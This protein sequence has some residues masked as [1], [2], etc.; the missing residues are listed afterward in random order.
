MIRG[1]GNLRGDWLEETGE[2]R[3]MTVFSK[4]A[5]VT[6]AATMVA[7]L[8]VL[9][10][11]SLM[12]VDGSP[13][14][15]PAYTA[16]VGPATVSVGFV[17][18]EGHQAEDAINC[19]AY[20]GITLG[21]SPGRFSPDLPITRWQ[22]ALFLTRAA[23]PAGI[24]LPAPSDQGFRDLDTKQY[25]QDAINQIAE[26][27]ISRG[28]S[29][30]TFHPH[31][32]MDRRQ[33]ALFLYRFL[34][35]SPRGPGGADT[36]SVVPDDTVFTD[37]GGQPDAVQAA[38]GVIYEMGVTLGKSA[39]TFAPT[40]LVTRAQMALFMTRALAHTNS[41][42]V[43]V[44]V[45]GRADVVS[46]GDTLEVHV[47]V[48]DSNLRPRSGS[49]VDVFSTPARD[50]YASFGP[51]GECLR[52]VEVAF[53]GRVCTIDQSDQ[54]LDGMGN[55][56]VI[57]E[58]TD[59]MRLWAWTGSSGEEFRVNDTKSG[60]IR[61]EV[62]KPATAVRVRDDMRSTAAVAKLG[63]T[64]QMTFELVDEDSRL[65]A[66]P[67]VRIQLATTYETNGVSGRTNIRTYRTGDDGK[68][69]VR[70]PAPDPD[71]ASG[72][73]TVRVDVDVL[74]QPL[75]VVDRT[76]LR[77]VENDADDAAD[78]VIT[79][80]EVAPVASTLRLG[81]VASFNQLVGAA[82]GPVN[83]VRAT[84]TDQYGDPVE[85]AMVEFSS[86]QTPGLGITGVVRT[87]GSG[88]V[89]TVRYMWNGTD[90]A[91]EL[92]SAEVSGLSLEAVPVN[93]YWAVP[94][95]GGKSALGVPILVSSVADNVI[96]HDVKSPRLL[97]YDDNDRFSIRDVV[98]G[99]STF[100]EALASGDYSRITYNKYYDDPE[101][102]SSF[103]LTNTRLF[104]SA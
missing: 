60:S 68:V 75:E 90:A 51:E 72:G 25:V 43:G 69:V 33:M 21:T 9:A 70:F 67:G 16:C 3:N 31:A 99:M 44:T 50:P 56:V 102:M 2:G 82:L 91:T 4:R 74:E 24:T 78:A 41:R 73:D 11:G 76:T 35:L 47:S 104:D 15:L 17:D 14:N 59:N 103:D 22:M 94:L 26:L 45:Q 55:L 38:V 10:P 18:T 29:P 36:A 63:D 61:I 13:D 49:L 37:L 23:G 32:P 83:V 98:V 1:T 5:V 53:G 57:L 12:A 34:L 20:Y 54:R 79:W 19:L 80:S 88:G 30:T 95:G 100:E 48:R 8:L 52:S 96:L 40:D 87:T 62:L 97:L 66:E 86:D 93:H 92:I 77:V 39:T 84:L 71:R 7:S 27:G 6:L 28:T 46:S 85:D 58:P 65:V 101:K 81:Q 89:A 42:P 64:L